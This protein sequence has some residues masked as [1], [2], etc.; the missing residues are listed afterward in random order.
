MQQVSFAYN[1]TS[2]VFSVL[3]QNGGKDE[4][5]TI[6]YPAGTVS[7]VEVFDSGSG[8]WKNKPD[9]L[10]NMKDKVTMNFGGRDY[11]YHGLV[12]RRSD[13]PAKSDYRVTFSKGQAYN[14]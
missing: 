3:G 13:S 10:D 9:Y 2:L 4:L 6:Y 12:I 7:K 8:Q 11:T 5:V 14:D 1:V